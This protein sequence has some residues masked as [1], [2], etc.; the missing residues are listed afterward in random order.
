[1]VKV[2]K[3][4]GVDGEMPAL[5]VTVGVDGADVALLEMG[6]LEHDGAATATTETFAAAALEPM[7]NMGGIETDE[8]V[9]TQFAAAVD[10]LAADGEGV[11][12]RTSVLQGHISHHFWHYPYSRPRFDCEN[13]ISEAGRKSKGNPEG[14]G[15]Q[16]KGSEGVGKIPF[17]NGEATT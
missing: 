13:T 6:A 9:A 2:A 16:E 1:M 8:E 14:A 7:V 3:V 15:E 17:D 11:Q 10:E 4:A 12:E 5:A